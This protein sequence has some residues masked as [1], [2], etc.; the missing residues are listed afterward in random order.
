MLDITREKAISL[1]DAAMMIP[2]MEGK[3]VHWR[4]VWKWA[5]YGL[6]GVLLETAMVGGR[7]V[8]TKEALQRFSHAI[9]EIR[10][11]RSAVQTPVLA[12]SI[13]RK[14]HEAAMKR[15]RDV[16]GVM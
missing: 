6:R 4:T 13:N 11:P 9:S 1:K 16:H 3:A 10:Q 14:A 8:T 7:R 5:Y 12:P 2:G 15:L